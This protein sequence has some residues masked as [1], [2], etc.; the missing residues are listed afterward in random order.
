MTT[1]KVEEKGQV[2]AGGFMGMSLFVGDEIKRVASREDRI[3]P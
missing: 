3:V 2:D 1:G